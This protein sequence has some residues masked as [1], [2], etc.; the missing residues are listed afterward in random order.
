VVVNNSSSYYYISQVPSGL[1]L[2]DL[3]VHFVKYR[4]IDFMVFFLVR[5]KRYTRHLTNLVFLACTVIYGHLFSTP[6]YMAWV[7]ITR[8]M[9]WGG[10]R[11]GLWLAVQ[12]WNSVSEWYLL[13]TLMM[14]LYCVLHE[15][16]FTF[17]VVF[18]CFN[19]F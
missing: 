15:L 13:H 11:R 4:P 10:R 18:I 16:R 12:P 17:S 9:G 3:G 14:Y 1:W 7:S 6:Q 19:A 8:D 5:S 2:V